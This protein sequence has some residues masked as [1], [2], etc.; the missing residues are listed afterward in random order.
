MMTPAESVSAPSE[1]TKPVAPHEFVTAM[2]CFTSGVAVVTSRDDGQPVGATVAAIAPIASDP[3]TVMVSL[4]STS[5]TALAIL[6]TR[7]FAINILDEDAAAVAGRFAT[8]DADRFAGLKFADD[9]LE[10]RSWRAA[11]RHSAA[12]SWTRSP[13][14]H[15]G[16]FAPAWLV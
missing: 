15:I 12:A 3:A 5:R 8:R 11:S 7:T 4:S 10:T 9:A 13:P 16:S 6:R 2:N 14:D 1:L